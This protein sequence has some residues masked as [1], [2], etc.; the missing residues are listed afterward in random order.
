YQWYKNGVAISGATSRQYTLSN[1]TLANAGDY[2]CVSTN[3]QMTITTV[4]NQN[5][6]LTRNTIHLNVNNCNAFLSSAVGTN[7]QAIC[8]STA[9]IPIT[10]TTAGL[11]TGATF[12]GLPAGVTGN[13]TSNTVTISGT[14]ASTGTFP[15]TVTYTGGCGAVVTSTGTITVQTKTV[16]AASAAPVLCI[17]TAI[18]PITHATQGGTLTLG[19]PTGLPSGVTAA[20]ATNILTISGTP[21]ASGVFNYSIPLL[22]GCGNTINA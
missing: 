20:W 18:I 5:L 6:V 2:H 15:Y 21:T 1:L 9:I 7:A 13:F 19:I 14:P 4:T 16:N 10:Y 8:P 22:G 17:N 12:S 3:P 11:I